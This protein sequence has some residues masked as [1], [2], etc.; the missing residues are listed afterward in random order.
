MVNYKI[1]TNINKNSIL[2][3]H[4]ILQKLIIIIIK[5]C[6]DA[7]TCNGPKFTLN[8]IHRPRWIVLL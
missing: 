7:K 6:T 8:Q 5:N 1:K 2:K 3:K 4:F